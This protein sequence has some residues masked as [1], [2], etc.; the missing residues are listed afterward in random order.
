MQTQSPTT[1]RQYK[2]F[3]HTK[4]IKHAQELLDR[5]KRQQKNLRSIRINRDTIVQ[6]KS[7][8]PN[9]E[10]II[11]RIRHKARIINI[12]DQIEYGQYA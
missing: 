2:T 8:N 3:D 6:I 7:D 4:A 9:L 10:K 12:V 5:T 11:D 1:K